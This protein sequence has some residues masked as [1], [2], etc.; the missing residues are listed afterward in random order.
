MTESSFDPVKSV[1]KMKGTL[2][3]RGHRSSHVSYNLHK[4]LKQCHLFFFL[5]RRFK[6]AKI[7]ESTIIKNELVA[8]I[9]KKG[10][11]DNPRTMI[12]YRKFNVDTIN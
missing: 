1:P 12:K 8:K 2:T 11:L 5:Q 4:I 9:I 6:W 7:P 3:T 10:D